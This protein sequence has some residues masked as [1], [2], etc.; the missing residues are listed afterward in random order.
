[1]GSDDRVAGPVVPTAEC[2]GHADLILSYAGR[3]L[4]G[5]DLPA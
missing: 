1:M 4:A 3:S 2:F 5:T